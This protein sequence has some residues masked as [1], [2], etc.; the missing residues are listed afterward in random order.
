[1]AKVLLFAVSILIILLP[2]SPFIHQLAIPSL[3]SSLNSIPNSTPL[4]LP[5]D[6][7]YSS[8]GHLPN[9]ATSAF[10]LSRAG[11]P[12]LAELSDANL[13]KI[14]HF[15]PTTANVTS[16]LE[17]NTLV[18]KCLGYRHVVSTATS[19]NVRVARMRVRC[20]YAKY[21][22]VNKGG[23]RIARSELVFLCN[24]RANGAFWTGRLRSDG[25]KSAL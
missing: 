24:E 20:T 7:D 13:L 8:R 22:C 17:V 18:W 5:V 12:A 6:A 16:D 4:P 25:A 14:L 23:E 2:A 3:S 15:P 19:A 10:I 11:P 9:A 21:P 1:M